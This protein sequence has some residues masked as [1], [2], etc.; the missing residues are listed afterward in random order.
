VAQAL[1]ERWGAD[2]AQAKLLAHLSG[3]RLGWAVRMLEDKAGLDRRTQRLD[4]LGKLLNAPTTE[5]FHYANR[6]A[7]DPV[8]IQETL[9]LWLG[10]WRDVTLLAAKADAPLTNI[11][12]TDTLRDH[13]RRYGLEHSTAMVQALCDAADHLQHNANP[14]LTLEV[15]MLDLPRS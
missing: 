5:R 11:D 8:A 13:A 15:L 1:V 4:D 6:L 9:D 12:Q 2:P 3:G 14:R 10:W 7:R